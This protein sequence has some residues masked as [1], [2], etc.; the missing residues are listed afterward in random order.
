M[1]SKEIAVTPTPLA[2]SAIEPVAAAVPVAAM[3]A[4]NT[5]ATRA[6]VTT[7]T[8]VWGQVTLT[9]GTLAASTTVPLL[10]VLF[11]ALYSPAVGE[12]SDKVPGRDEHGLE[13]TLRQK[14]WAGETATTR[15]RFFWRPDIHGNMQVYGVHTGEGT[16]YE[17]VRVAN[18]VWKPEQSRYEFTPAPGVDGPKITW[19]P[20]N[21]EGSEPLSQTETPVAPID[22]PTILVHPIPDGTE[23]T[24]TPPFPMPDEH[25]FNDWIL[26]FPAD[27][28][29][30]PIYVYL[31]STARD[32]PG[33]VTGQGERLTGEGKWLDAASSG[34]GA[35]IP[36][37]VADKLRGREFKTFD[38]FRE[39]FWLAVAN[40]P[41][42]FIQF[43]RGNLGNIKSGKAPSPKEVEQVGGR[44]K[45]ELHHVKLISEEGEVYNID[46]IRVVTPKRHIEIHRGK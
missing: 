26:V 38:A 15:V 25:D 37:Q 35:P 17:G 41:E 28:G 12:G 6:A 27:S 19:T 3:S 31:K 1:S 29:I 13:D 46:N 33:I 2:E 32:E 7:M 34:L 14:G 36:A 4:G 24:T 18:M 44:I 5:V 8:Q 20:A 23:E 43:K 11:S 39:A 30:K 42:L 45:Y 10:G 21:P 22:Q 9:E 40:V 16:P